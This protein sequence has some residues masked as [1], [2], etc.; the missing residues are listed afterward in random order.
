MECLI[1]M[2]TK[3]E[4]KTENAKAEPK[5]EGAKP[6]D[7]SSAVQIEITPAP[8]EAVKLE[9]LKGVRKIGQRL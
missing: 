7:E 4:P 8:S 9:P 6:R 3:T 1:K 5:P 2:P